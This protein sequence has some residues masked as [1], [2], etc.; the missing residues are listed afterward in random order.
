MNDNQAVQVKKY[1]SLTPYIV[2]GLNYYA[3]YFCRMMLTNTSARSCCGLAL[4]SFLFLRVW[5]PKNVTWRCL[6]KVSIYEFRI[7]SK[8]M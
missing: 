7:Y 3:N 5:L 8:Y 4:I 2:P 6:G 1:S